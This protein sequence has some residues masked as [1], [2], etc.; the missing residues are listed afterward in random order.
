VIR[1]SGQLVGDSLLRLEVELNVPQRQSRLSRERSE[2]LTIIVRERSRSA[3]DH[4]HAVGTS[5]ALHRTE[6]DREHRS[7]VSLGTAPRAGLERSAFGLMNRRLERADADRRGEGVVRLG[8][9]SE[10]P[11]VGLKQRRSPSVM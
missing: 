10:P 7:S 8:A 4:D 11:R 9:G 2:Q 5:H 3:R 6:G 1:E